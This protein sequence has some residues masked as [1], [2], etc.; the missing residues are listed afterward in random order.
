MLQSL[1]KAKFS[2]QSAIIRNSYVS[3]YN[4]RFGNS[5]KPTQVLKYKRA[6]LMFEIINY[7][8]DVKKCTY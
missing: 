8:K 6:Y 1:Q 2:F 4:L 7:Y 5:K 3:D